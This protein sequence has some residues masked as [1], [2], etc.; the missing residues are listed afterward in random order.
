MSLRRTARFVTSISSSYCLSVSLFVF[1]TAVILLRTIF[2]PSYIIRQI[3]ISGFSEQV[4]QELNEVYISYG[5]ASGI[6]SE[7]MAS[8]LTTRHVT[9]AVESS[10]LKA[11]NLSVNYSFEDFSNEVY[12][13]LY[14]Y[15]VSQGINATDE[16][17]IGLRDLA[18]LCVVALKVYVDPPV[19]ELLAQ[20]QRFS[21]PIVQAIA[22]SAAISFIAI[23]II[24]FVNRRVTG[25][26]DGFIYALGSVTLISV[27]LPM[28]IIHLGLTSRLQISPLSLNNLISSCISG[29]LNSYLIALFPLLLLIGICVTVRILRWNRRKRIYR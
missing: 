17:E 15:V 13:K 14:D 26:I 2:N 29:I 16:L 18:D 11:Y 6:S 4:V 25:W 5:L 8:L 12:I 9:N 3:E 23:A 19:F 27:A 20:A 7:L 21:R 10:I 1:I 24:L 28:I 22:V